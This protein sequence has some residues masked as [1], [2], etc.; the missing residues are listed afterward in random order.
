M[1][2]FVWGVYCQKDKLLYICFL[3][4][5]AVRIACNTVVSSTGYCGIV[6]RIDLLQHEDK[7]YVNIDCLSVL[8]PTE[9]DVAKQHFEDQK[10]EIIEKAK[11][12]LSLGEIEI[13]L[14]GNR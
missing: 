13:L 3:E 2:N 9:Q 14:G 8:Q 7:S 6:K 1:S 11:A 10:A 5:T 4:S 12:V